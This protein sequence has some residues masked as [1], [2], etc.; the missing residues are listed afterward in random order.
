MSTWGLKSGIGRGD[1]RRDKGNYQEEHVGFADILP[2]A[3]CAQGSVC[4][5]VLAAC[6]TASMLYCL[7][8]I[9]VQQPPLLQS[10]FTMES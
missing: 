2:D 4:E 9:V 10:V 6:V 8:V 7:A 1:R 5:I 3:K